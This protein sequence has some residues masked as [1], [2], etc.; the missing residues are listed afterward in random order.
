MLDD[1]GVSTAT[2]RSA[3]DLDALLGPR[4]R[5]RHK[6]YSISVNDQALATLPRRRTFVSAGECLDLQSYL[7]TRSVTCTRVPSVTGDRTD[8]SR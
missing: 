3:I 1:A 2:I 5:A 7:S 4:C 6:T 8:S